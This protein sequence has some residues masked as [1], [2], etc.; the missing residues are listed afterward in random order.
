MN[1]NRIIAANV[2]GLL[3][4]ALGAFGIE[5]TPEQREALVAGIAGVGCLIN[6][7]LA[8]AGKRSAK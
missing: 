8:V 4:V 7:G 2:A 3:V 5:V 6:I 1:T